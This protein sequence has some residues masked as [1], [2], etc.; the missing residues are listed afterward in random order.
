LQLLE[1]MGHLLQWWNVIMVGV[2]WRCI[3]RWGIAPKAAQD[4]CSC[5]P[6]VHVQQNYGEWSKLNNAVCIFIFILLLVT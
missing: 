4:D 2:T 1:I 6:H 5:A 3:S